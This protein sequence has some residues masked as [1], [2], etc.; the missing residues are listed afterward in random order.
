VV[1]VGDDAKVTDVREV[2]HGRRKVGVLE[3]WSTGVLG[4]RKYPCD[5]ITGE[6]NVE[7]PPPA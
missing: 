4:K 1:N 2:G 5:E 7:Q 6:E 3:Y